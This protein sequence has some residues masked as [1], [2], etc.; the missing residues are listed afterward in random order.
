[1]AENNPL[2][3]YSK[4]ISEFKA[5]KIEKNNLRYGNINRYKTIQTLAFD[6]L[7]D[8]VETITV[9]YKIKDIQKSDKEITFAVAYVQKKSNVFGKLKGHKQSRLESSSNITLDNICISGSFISKDGEY[10]STILNIHSFNYLISNNKKLGD[11]YNEIL[12]YFKNVLLERK[13]FLMTEYYFP[14]D[15][16]K[17]DFQY[18]T[19]ILCSNNKIEIFC[20]AWYNFY[21]TYYFGLISN[22]INDIY[23]NIMLKYNQEDLTFFKSLLKKYDN[24]TLDE[25]RYICHNYIINEAEYQLYEKNKIGQKIIP[26]NLLEA[27]NFFNIQYAP[28]KEYLINVK[29]SSLVM[30]N[31][32]NGFSISGGWFII[33]NNNKLFYDNPSQSDRLEKSQVALKIA[34]LLSSAKI[35]THHTINDRDKE[36]SALDNIDNEKITT[37]LSNEFKNLFNMIGDTIDTAKER[38]I[39]SN[40]SLCII[41]EYVGK[42]LYDAIFL[43]NK[44]KFYKTLVTSMFSVENQKNFRKYMFQLC[45]NLLCINKKLH[46]IHG[47]LHL[48]NITLNSIFYK[49]N[50]NVS[51]KNPKIAYKINQDMFIFDNNFYDLCIIDF[52]RSIVNIEYYEGLKSIHPYD[53]IT[54]QADFSNKQTQDLLSYLYNSKPEYRDFG[55]TLENNIKHHFDEFFKVL[56]VLDLYNLT[57]KFIELVKSDNLVIKSPSKISLKLISDLNKSSEYYLSFVLNKLISERN[58]D[59]INKMEYPIHTIIKDIFSADLDDNLSSVVDIYNFNSPL[60]NNIENTKKIFPFF[61]DDSKKAIR[62]KYDEKSIYNYKVVNII[63]ARQLEKNL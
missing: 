21:H 19:E 42:T 50:V 15:K 13:Y 58:F 47:D 48:N 60:E 63:Q 9:L 32:S 46:V 29:L 10:R 37:W 30:N 26:L 20:I 12:R 31:I 59:E 28:W 54:S 49:K 6:L 25:F 35:Y 40:V 17:N 34:E 24:E 14:T 44:S 18:E 5:G 8:T 22:H 1:M 23:K 51:V 11:I 55:A 16:I 41:N 56:S 39:M 36:T 4:R 33:K 3:F 38:I 57:T 61:M 45:Y 53:I 52:S 43:T 27:Q 2:S 62:R 7:P